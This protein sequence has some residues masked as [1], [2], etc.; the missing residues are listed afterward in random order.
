LVRFFISSDVMRRLVAKNDATSNAAITV[1][2]VTLME[3]RVEN[4]AASNRRLIA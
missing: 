3:I 1:A 2:P 4:L